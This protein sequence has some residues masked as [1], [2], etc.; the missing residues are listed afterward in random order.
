MDAKSESVRVLAVAAD[1]SLAEFSV[2][3]SVA[4]FLFL[5]PVISKYCASVVRRDN[6]F[7]WTSRSRIAI[8]PNIR[9]DRRASNAG[10]IF[11]SDSAQVFLNRIRCVRRPI[12]V[13]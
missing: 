13:L 10:L 6:G 8:I 2:G 4:R 3:I 11:R 7:Q 12:R 1:T 5:P 9:P